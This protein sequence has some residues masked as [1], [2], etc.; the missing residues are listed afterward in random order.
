MTEVDVE[1]RFWV[2]DFRAIFGSL[3]TFA[4]IGPTLETVTN[5][6]VTTLNKEC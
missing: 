2:G 1:S 3:L 4:T 6:S 5:K